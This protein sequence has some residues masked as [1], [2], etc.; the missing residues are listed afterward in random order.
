M[1]GSL[2]TAQSRRR[3][4]SPR[5]R[6]APLE[7]SAHV[8]SYSRYPPAT[9][10]ASARPGWGAHEYNYDAAYH[11][12]PSP[13]PGDAARYA[14]S[15]TL[16]RTPQDDGFGRLVHD[17]EAA[18]S[19]LWDQLAGAV[20]RV[21]GGGSRAEHAENGHARDVLPKERVDTAAARFSCVSPEVCIPIYS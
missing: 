17:A 11:A 1:N 3:S 9:G 13:G 4:P 20:Q 19:R 5:P 18:P 7:P 2:G 8:S 16:I 21:V 10:S 12:L 14:Y 6:P 15:T